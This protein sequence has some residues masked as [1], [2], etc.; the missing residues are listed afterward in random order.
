MEYEYKVTLKSGSW[1]LFENGILLDQAVKTYGE[2][3]D[4]IEL[5]KKTDALIKETR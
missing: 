4:K 5:V 2:A 1:G 3:I